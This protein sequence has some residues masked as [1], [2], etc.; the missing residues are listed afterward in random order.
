MRYF[1]IMVI[2]LLAIHM[3]RHQLELFAIILLSTG[4]HFIPSGIL[5]KENGYYTLKKGNIHNMAFSFLIEN[6]FHK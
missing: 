2:W 5:C 3:L 1:I 4:E 6:H